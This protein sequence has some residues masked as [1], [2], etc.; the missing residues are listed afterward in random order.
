MG[1]IKFRTNIYR[2]VGALALLIGIFTMT[3]CL[4]DE[5]PQPQNVAVAMM[6]N[7]VPNQESEENGFI[8]ALDNNQLNNLN[9]QFPEYFLYGETLQYR[10]VFPG[11]RLFRAYHPQDVS[12]NDEILSET[13]D[14]E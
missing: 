4:K 8:L 1:Q 9:H 6:I 2:T 14:F 13:V 12:S 10:R 5:D 7:A 11:E 3:S